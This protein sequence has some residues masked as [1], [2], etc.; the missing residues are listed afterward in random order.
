MYFINWFVG[1]G[2]GPFSTGELVL[3]NWGALY[4]SPRGRSVAHL[5]RA[6]AGA[7]DSYV[8]LKYLMWRTGPFRLLLPALAGAAVA[9]GGWFLFGSEEQLT[10][11]LAGVIGAALLA[12]RGINDVQL[13]PP[14]GTRRIA[15]GN[16]RKIG[17]DDPLA[18]LIASFDAAAA[19]VTQGRFSKRE[20]LLLRETMWQLAGH[21]HPSRPDVEALAGQIRAAAG[22]A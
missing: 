3:R 21:D 16:E 15:V 14:A 5:L 1:V 19:Q 4:R 18:D 2:P 13:K 8:L 9:A 6:D 7:E 20:W 12:V 22:S 11:V 10:G 17:A